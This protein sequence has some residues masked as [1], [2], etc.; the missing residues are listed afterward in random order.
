MKIANIQGFVGTFAVLAILVGGGIA[1]SLNSQRQVSS[2]ASVCNKA[3]CPDGTC[4]CETRVC[5]CVSCDCA[6][7]AKDGSCC[8]IKGATQLVS[9]SKSDNAGGCCSAESKAGSCCASESKAGG[10]CSA[11]AKSGSCANDTKGA[12][13]SESGVSA[14]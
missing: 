3:C 11:E 4:C 10:C 2:D 7:C 1:A 9:A 6:C 5:S 14:K 13:C 12:C 8:E